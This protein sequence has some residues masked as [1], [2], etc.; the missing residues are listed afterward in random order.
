MWDVLSV[1]RT[2]SNLLHSHSHSHPTPPLIVHRLCFCLYLLPLCSFCNAPYDIQS[3]VRFF[4]AFNCFFLS[5]SHTFHFRL[6]PR[7]VGG[8]Q[9][10]PHRYY[11][12]LNNFVWTYVQATSYT[13]G[14]RSDMCGH[15]RRRVSKLPIVLR[16]SQITL[17]RKARRDCRSNCVERG[18]SFR[19]LHRE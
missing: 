1:V 13:R 10:L 5:E 9:K 17:C 14:G 6:R 18:S 11:L 15:H 3:V 7:P 2:Y 16:S 4:N 8:K 12:T 19:R